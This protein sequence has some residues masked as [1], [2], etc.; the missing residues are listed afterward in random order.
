MHPHVPSAPLNPLLGANS[1]PNKLKCIM[2]SV[3]DHAKLAAFAASCERLS[4]LFLSLSDASTLFGPLTP[5]DLLRALNLPSSSPS[6][7]TRTS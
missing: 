4:S 5:P 3:N 1:G 6:C 7:Q 2:F